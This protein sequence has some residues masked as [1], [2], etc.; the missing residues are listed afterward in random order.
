VRTH[1]IV[2]MTAKRADVFVEN[3]LHPGRFD[4]ARDH[5]AARSSRPSTHIRRGA[6]AIFQG[7]PRVRHR[8]AAQASRATGARAA[9]GHDARVA[10]SLARCCRTGSHTSDQ[11]L[12]SAPPQRLLAPPRAHDSHDG[13]LGIKRLA[14]RAGPR[15][16][17]TENA[18]RQ[19][20]S[21]AS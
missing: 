18:D 19:E 21:G 15:L 3:G 12:P 2:E 1:S 16:A 13:I 7:T 17:H 6:C 14:R 20:A 10:R 9:V 11:V 8:A 5:P 4:I